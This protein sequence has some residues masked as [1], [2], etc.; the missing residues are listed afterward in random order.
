VVGHFEKQGPETFSIDPKPSFSFFLDIPGEQHPYATIGQSQHQG[1]LVD[2]LGTICPPFGVPCP[3]ARGVQHLHL[4][5]A[6]RKGA[7]VPAKPVY[8]NPLLPAEI[9]QT[10]VPLCFASY[11][12]TYPEFAGL[13]F[14]CDGVQA[15][16]VIRL[17]V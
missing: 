2:P 6:Y 1:P 16:V 13:Q 17:A 11:L 14:F 4:H 3:I 8:P 9:E 7:N 5:P 12:R 10:H 15:P